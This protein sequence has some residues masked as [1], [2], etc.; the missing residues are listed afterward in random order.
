VFESSGQAELAIWV[1]VKH[2]TGPSRRQLYDYVLAQHQRRIASRGAVVL[3]APRQGYEWFDAQEIPDSVLRLKWQE[4]AALLATYPA[5]SEVGTFLVH[6]L[7]LYLREE[8]LMDPDRITAEHLV[9]FAQHKEAFEALDLLCSAATAYIAETWAA[10]TPEQYGSR[11]GNASWWIFPTCRVGGIPLEGREFDFNLYRDGSAIFRNG[12]QGVPVFTVGTSEEPGTVAAIDPQTADDLTN[13]GFE[14]LPT[15]S[16]L[17]NPWDR[18]WRRAYPDEL[19]AGA[20]LQKQGGSL[21]RWVVDAFEQLHDIL[22]GEETSQP[23]RTES[24]A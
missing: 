9:A 14:L 11:S 19:L 4:T 21:A 18:I 24:R 10:L 3:I 15:Q 20:T 22:A 5:P 16:L 1:E 23:E 12:R 6:E 17:S 7:C 8:G 13:A 2:G